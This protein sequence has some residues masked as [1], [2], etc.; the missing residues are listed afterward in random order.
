MTVLVLARQVDQQVDR[1]VEELTRRGVRVFRTDLAAFPQRLTL[2]ARLGPDGWCGMLATKHR[3]VRLEDICSVWYRHPSH[4]E[5]AE[6]M[7]RPERRHA[8]QE[9]R[10]YGWIEDQLGFP[11]TSALADLLTKETR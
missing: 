2:D 3:R 4:F 11:V 6:G 7:S 8:A 10:A 1:V 5:L 9:A